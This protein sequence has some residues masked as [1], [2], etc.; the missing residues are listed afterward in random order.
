MYKQCIQRCVQDH[1]RLFNSNNYNNNYKVLCNIL[2]HEGYDAHVVS[3]FLNSD[4]TIKS[5]RWIV[6]RTFIVV[7]IENIDGI[8]CQ[9]IFIDLN[10]KDAFEIACPTE[11]YTRR[12]ADVP[13]IF[14]GSHGELFKIVLEMYWCMDDSFKKKG[15]SIAPHR[16]LS[17]ML[18]R[19]NFMIN[20]DR[21][22]QYNRYYIPCR[23]R[24]MYRV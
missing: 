3:T 19:W 6:P 21:Y 1:Y 10:F 13:T 22:D 11:D 12:L 14:V 20:L 8:I 9:E 4:T 16:R 15:M 5:S 17:S 24:R 18:C 23:L 2:Q 7:L